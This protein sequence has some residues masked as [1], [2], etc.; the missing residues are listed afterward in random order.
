MVAPS[1]GEG[2]GHGAGHG[3]EHGKSHVHVR[4]KDEEEDHGRVPVRP[5]MIRLAGHFCG[6]ATT[7]SHCLDISLPIA[8]EVAIDALFPVIGGFLDG[9]KR[10]STTSGKGAEKTYLWSQ[11]L[12]ILQTDVVEGAA[13]QHQ[14]LQSRAEL[15]NR[16][17]SDMGK[18]LHDVILQERALEVDYEAKERLVENLMQQREVLQQK[19]MQLEHALHDGG[20]GCF[21]S[22]FTNISS[23]LGSSKGEKHEKGHGHEH[24]SDH[25][26]HGAHG[27]EHGSGHHAALE[28]PASPRPVEDGKVLLHGH[29]AGR[30]MTK[31]HCVELALPVEGTVPGAP[32]MQ[33]AA[34]LRQ[35][36]KDAETSVDEQ[37]WQQ[38][39]TLLQVD[40]PDVQCGFLTEETRPA[41]EA[42]ERRPESLAAPRSP[43]AKLPALEA[44]PAPAALTLEPAALEAVELSQ[45]RVDSLTKELAQLRG[46]CSRAKKE[47][48][49][50]RA[51]NQTLVSF[52]ASAESSA[53]KLRN[54]LLE[55]GFALPSPE[56]SPSKRKQA[57]SMDRTLKALEDTQVSR[58][59]KKMQPAD[60][61]E[62]QNWAS[63]LRS[64]Q[65][66]KLNA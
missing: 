4:E 28:E 8:D 31:G 43:V 16:D 12:T 59:S 10:S 42:Q 1:H 50:L 53:L 56:I 37:V 47:S 48:A 14:E 27:H 20:S 66:E 7:A 35:A 65:G 30:M 32:V 39:L 58:A 41:L 29:F 9:A 22:I 6:V 19:T 55:A 21:S 54:T 40:L 63:Q 38:L 24:S 34:A 46:E 5:G 2:H 33:M 15:T 23:A 61:Q 60:L 49:Q 13:R 36:A 45:S 64:I 57:T 52:L 62:L 44:S 26:A 25:H 18:Q 3:N 17:D 11:L 51:R